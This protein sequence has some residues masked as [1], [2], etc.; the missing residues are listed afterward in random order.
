[1]LDVYLLTLGL[2]VGLGF[3]A[4]FALLAASRSARFAGLFVPA[5][6][7]EERPRWGGVAIFIAFAATPFIASALSSHASELF[8][9]RSGDF[10]A[11]LGAC[12]LIFAVGFM[13]DL[14]LLRWQPRLAVQ[15]GAA[16]AV[17]AAGY[18]IA[19]VALPVGPEIGLGYFAPVATVL[20]IVFF[21]NAF[22]L[23]DGKDGVATG[24]VVLAATA[25]AV[26]AA[27]AHH[28]TVAL[29]LVALAG[30]GLGMLPS[31][32]P[33]AST[34]L[35]DSGATM[36]GFIVGALSIR[37]ATGFTE[38]VFISIPI[39][40]LG[41]PVLDQS[42]AVMRRLL[43]RRHPLVGDRD[44]IHHRLEAYGFGPRGLLLVIY[45]VSALF[46]G[47]ALL[48]H[49]IHFLPLEIA[50]FSGT[51][52]VVALILMK[53]GYVLTIWNSA[54]IVWLR[55]RLRWIEESP[56]LESPDRDYQG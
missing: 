13:D 8:S 35:G 48:I 11:F 16:A 1:M 34:Y 43:D 39:L 31:N 27:N 37:A 18:E 38:A 33:P 3:A 17:Y 53:L 21:T 24:V 51:V 55:R 7:V 5:R 4:T 2:A 45:S 23:I 14:R 12:A 32:L 42:L 30:A 28:P 10:L 36:L 25:L 44:H 22:N 19:S 6:G 56:L 50:V 49:H 26:V 46:A 40:I 41:F 54:S 29:L 20:W 52:L 9:P 15:V 47:G